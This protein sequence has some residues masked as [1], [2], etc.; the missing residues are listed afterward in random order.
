MSPLRAQA[1][2]I[3]GTLTIVPVPVPVASADAR[4]SAAGLDV[5]ARSSLAT[6]TAACSHAM[7]SFAM[8]TTG[9]S[10]RLGSRNAYCRIVGEGEARPPLAPVVPGAQEVPA[11]A[12][13]R[14][15]RSS[16]SLRVCVAVSRNT[17][18]RVFCAVVYGLVSRIIERRTERRGV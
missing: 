11:A 8:R 10:C 7:T 14:A 3:N 13:S 6:R 9:D 15:S 1:A 16:A 5:A 18:S 17:A 4:P 2:R 12:T